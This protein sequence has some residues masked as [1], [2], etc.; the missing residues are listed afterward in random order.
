MTGSYTFW[1]RRDTR[2]ASSSR[3]GDKN[4]TW[5]GE[6]TEEKKKKQETKKREVS[7]HH[8]GGPVSATYKKNT[9]ATKLYDLNQQT[10]QAL[11]R[12][13]GVYATFADT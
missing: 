10:M 12:L 1:S 13:A 9:E 5:R 3:H 6:R 7:Q 8:E 4:V 2:G 11:D